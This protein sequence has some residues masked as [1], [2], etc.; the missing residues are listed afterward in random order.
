VS[1]SVSTPTRHDV[2]RIAFPLILSNLS[3]PLLGMVDT[4]VVGHMG[5]AHYLGAVAVCSSIFSLL[6][7]GFNA[8]RMGTTGLV[9]QA[10]GKDDATA[11]R[12]IVLQGALVALAAAA[13][14]LLLQVPVRDLALRL[15]APGEQVLASARAYYDVRVWSAP[16][17]LV[18]YVIVGWLV[19]LQRTRWVLGMYLAVNLGNIALDLLF[20]YGFGLKVQGV[21]AAS[22]VAEGFGLAVGIVAVRRMLITQP[23]A[24][25]W[26][27]IWRSALAVAGLAR[28]FALNVN[29]LIRTLVLAFSVLLL[30]ALGARLGEVVLAANAIL[31]MFQQVISYGLD[32]FAHAAE[33]LVGRAVGAADR[34][35]LRRAVRYSFDWSVAVALAAALVL[36]FAGAPFADR[37]TDQPAVSDTVRRYLPWLVLSPLVS[38]WSFV[39]DGVFVGATAARQM[40]D[41]MLFASAIVYIPALWL[42]RG[43]GNHGLWAAFTLFMLARAFSMHWYYRRTLLARFPA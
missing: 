18:N 17:L 35:A 9:S 43:Y 40:R 11:L 21:A 22:V 15:I 26:R 23:S 8:L 34:D 36:A 39:Y 41:A 12:V 31:L 24:A 3:V 1:Q 27:A 16:A 25:P 10:H 37:L 13:V 38:L 19:G 42:L 14:I 2:L 4:A 5:A 20:V 29:L 30:T 28:L 6:F 7:V 33:A 32:G